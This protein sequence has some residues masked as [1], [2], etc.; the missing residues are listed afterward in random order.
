MATLTR[1]NLEIFI[2][3]LIN[4]AKGFAEDV[5]PKARG[6]AEKMV[7]ESE[8]YKEKRISTALGD[9]SRFNQI[10]SEYRKDKDVTKTRIY[11]EKLTEVLKKP[12]KVV[13]TDSSSGALNLLQLG[14][15]F[16]D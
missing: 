13:G 2:K 5:I 9:T 8:G 16:K 7:K 11:L 4:E 6:E 14:D 15:I 12:K 1:D 3:R 10:Y